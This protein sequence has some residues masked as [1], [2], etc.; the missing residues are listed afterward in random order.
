M[1]KVFKIAVWLLVI[2]IVLLGTV[3]L[4]AWRSPQY[5]TLKT[6]VITGDS[7]T[8]FSSYPLIAGHPRPYIIEGKNFVIIGATHTRDPKHPEIDQIEERWKALKPTVALVE[9]RLGFLLPGI[10]N[11]VKELGEGGKVQQL[12]K[13]DGV[14][15]YNWDYSK[16]VLATQL[17]TTFNAEQVALAQI[18]NPYFSNLRFGRPAS[19]ENFVR[20]Y[21]GRAR[22]VGQQEHFKTV[23]DVDRSWK[24]H[25]PESKDW[26]ET[27]DETALPGYLNDMM[28]RTNDLRN[29]RLVMIVKELVVRQE[30]VFLICGSSHAAC[31]A[32]AF[33]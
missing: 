10:M 1:K 26:R 8:P 11:P 21:L 14:P 33:Q 27:S 29:R 15:L 22:F 32:P 9:G 23:A 5:Y 2:V 7:I 12:A 16:D 28:V 13:A 25:F 31:V 4:I 3:Y 20:E 18:L 17:Q 24:K 6:V 30:R 19:P